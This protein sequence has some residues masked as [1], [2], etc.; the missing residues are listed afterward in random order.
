MQNS[1][2]RTV[3]D[4]RAQIRNTSSGLFAHMVAADSVSKEAIRLMEIGLKWE[5]FDSDPGSLLRTLGSQIIIQ[6]V[7]S[8]RSAARSHKLEGKKP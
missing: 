7:V 2:K 1:K 8:P 5:K 3:F 6:P 4:V